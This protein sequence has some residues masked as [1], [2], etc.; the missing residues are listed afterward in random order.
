[1]K[2]HSCSKGCEL[3]VSLG[4]QGSFLVE[5]GLCHR[6]ERYALEV[7]SQESETEALGVY[8]GFLA[9]K[10]GYRSHL[11]VTSDR[12]IKKSYFLLMDQAIEKIELTAPV[13]KG[14]LV[15]EDPKHPEIRVLASMSMKARKGK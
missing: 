2:C 14:Q 1:M 6:G 12:P 8:K 10:Q 9:V 4:N 15:Y 3:T 13:L 11:L 5:G 7:L